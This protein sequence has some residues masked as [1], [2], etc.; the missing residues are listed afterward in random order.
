VTL[1]IKLARQLEVVKDAI[2]CLENVHGGKRF[3]ASVNES[4]GAT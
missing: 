3:I 4:E 1:S 2:R